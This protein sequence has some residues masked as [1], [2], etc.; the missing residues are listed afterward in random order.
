ME[1]FHDLTGLGSGKT[2]QENPD[3]L[4]ARHFHCKYRKIF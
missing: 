4:P 2:P 3:G 1:S